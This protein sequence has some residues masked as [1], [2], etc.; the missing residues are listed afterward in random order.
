MNNQQLCL[1][2]VFCDTEK[3]VIKLL[4]EAG[5]WDNP[6]YWKYYGDNENNFATIGNQQG[7]PD[8]AIVEKIINSVDSLLMS[9][10]LKRGVDPSGEDSPQSIKASLKQYFNIP[11]GK[12]S[13]LTPSERR[14]LAENICLVATGRK[15]NPCYA[16]M[17]QGEGQTP[18]MMPDTLLSIGKSNKLRIP[19]VQG[20]FNM[21]GT[22][23]FQFCGKRNLQLIISKRHP[24][25]AA[26][27]SGPS[28][29]LW[30]FTIVRR[31]DPTHGV[32]SSF[33]RYIA[34]NGK[35]LSF[36]A[37]YLSLLPGEYPEAYGN[38][39]RWGTYIKLYEYQMTGL[40]TNVK[41][42]LYYRLSLL[43]P[44]IA[45]PIRLYERR[46]DFK[47]HTQE[48]T[49]SGLTVRLEEDKRENL[50][51]GFPTSS[52]LVVQGQKMKISIFAF[53]RGHTE[54]YT[55][56][57]GIIFIVNGQTHGYLSKSFFSRQYVRMGYLA[58][59]LLVLV[60]CTDFDGRTREDL[61]MNSRDRLRAGELKS[62]IERQLE[63]IL[64]NHQGLK[65]LRE[66]R[67]REDIENKLEDSKPLADIIESIIKKS[68]TLSK[69][70]IQGVKLP[71]PFKTTKA[72]AQESFKGKRFP[73]YF[74]LTRE[75]QPDS[76]KR[77]PINVRLRVQYKTDVENEYFNRDNA[78]GSFAVKANGNEI[79]DF[80]VNLWNGLATLN[81]SIPEDTQVGDVVRFCS[82]VN[83]ASRVDPI[84]EKFYVLVEDSIERTSGLPG[85][86][87]PPASDKEGN[88]V[89]QSTYLD[90]PNIFEVRQNEWER[91]KFD[92][93]GALMVRDSGEEGYDFFI[94]M[95]NVYLLTEK[96]SNTKVNPKLLDA[97]YKYGMVLLG[98]ALLKANRTDKKSTMSESNSEMNVYKKIAYFTKV[99]SAIL[100][101]MISGLGELREYELVA[102][103][104]DE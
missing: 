85:K 52:T 33:Y 89:E 53:K 37:E 46:K 51:G 64:R 40:K 25:V 9:E 56:S 77:C 87:K 43:M 98:I 76:P 94:N 22:G 15:S 55:K 79:S 58:D 63:E 84:T 99:V 42:D 32:R 104:E 10:C 96:K 70:F 57:E 72:K 95:D 47:G 86:R 101:P 1:G 13:N 82:E 97:R 34:P 39:L 3:D 90:L 78:Q 5:Y 59:S 7:R 48:I 28:S 50:E 102:T 88:D 11:N 12:L 31:E 83:D 81:V 65:D 73:T 61:F 44:S 19:F 91:F 24:G 100:L 49:L 29:P 74:K 41:F 93:E 71:N 2:L 68:P 6:S 45:L 35:I 18:I 103:Y 54:K 20:K 16:I 80:S 62:R 26:H 67:R 17:D 75:Y 27:E 8:A 30:G 69:L 66:R 92:R 23:V 14:K 38:P 21:G 36:D 4:K 60:D